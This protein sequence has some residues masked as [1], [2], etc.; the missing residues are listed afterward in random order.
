MKIYFASDLHLGTPTKQ[1]SRQRELLFVQWLDTVSKDAAEIF[2]KLANNE[3]DEEML[4]QQLKRVRAGE[5]PAEVDPVADPEPVPTPIVEDEPKAE[6]PEAN[7][8][9]PEANLSEP[10]PEPEDVKI[11]RASK[12]GRA[13][14][15]ARRAA[16]QE[17]VVYLDDWRERDGVRTG[18]GV[19][20]ARRYGPDSS[21]SED[22]GWFFGS[23]GPVMGAP[24][25][26]DLHNRLRSDFLC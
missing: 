3:I 16:R 11:D 25:E 17:I 6:E 9:E 24:P 18:A 2:L 26:H 7:P 5:D 10:E 15:A 14:A 1:A 19:S 8:T 12:G 22:V 20:S 21:S 23:S 13:S 4:R